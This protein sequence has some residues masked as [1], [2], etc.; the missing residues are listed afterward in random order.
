MKFIKK[1]DE[2]R[3][4]AEMPFLD[5]LEELRWCIIKSLISVLIITVVCFFFYEYLFEILLI[6][7]NKLDPPLKLQAIKV[8]TPFMILLEIA[9][10][11]GIVLSIP[12]IFYQIWKFVSPGLLRYEKTIVPALAASTLL[13]FSLGALFA[14]F[15]IIP[16]ALN[17]FRNIS[18]GKIDYNISI[19]FYL[20]FILR[21]IIVFGVVFLL[22][23]LSFILTKIGLLT[24][25]FMRKYRRY[26][27][28]LA[29]VLGA[30]LTPP[31]VITQVFLAVPLIILYEIS[32]FISYIFSPKQKKTALQK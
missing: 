23:I 11:M 22:P 27:I 6:P 12:I 10:I 5:H 16:N 30:I 1:K 28:V 18:A 3:N 7:G 4:K 8:Q 17:F 26:A 14:Y 2:E 25:K 29:F 13:C 19:D 15:I 21:L 24:P 31:D 32:I 9:L 20:G